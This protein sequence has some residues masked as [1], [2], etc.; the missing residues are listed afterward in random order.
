MI[1]PI[2][3]HHLPLHP[4]SLSCLS[5]IREH[6]K[7]NLGKVIK[8]RNNSYIQ[9]RIH[10]PKYVLYLGLEGALELEFYCILKFSYLSYITF[11]VCLFYTSIMKI[12]DTPTAFV[13]NVCKFIYMINKLLHYTY[14]VK[15]ILGLLVA[16][17]IDKGELCQKQ[18][19]GSIMSLQFKIWEG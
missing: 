15:T 14:N 13:G 19:Q 6:C 8:V 17:D 18:T 10:L 4:P 11:S 5:I 12:Y 16:I 2:H 1:L 3:S 9:D 7:D